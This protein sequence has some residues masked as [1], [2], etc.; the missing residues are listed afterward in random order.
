MKTEDARIVWWNMVFPKHMHTIDI[1]P[2]LIP[3]SGSGSS[4]GIATDYGLDSPGIESQWGRDFSPV[5]TGPPS[6]LYNGYWVLPRGKE[7]PGR[8]ADSSLPFSAVVMKE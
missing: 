4:V 6:L 3:L 7:R 1:I 2:P 8:D 5:Q